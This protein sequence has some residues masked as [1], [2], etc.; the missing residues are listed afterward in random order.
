MVPCCAVSLRLPWEQGV[1]PWPMCQQCWSSRCAMKSCTWEMCCVGHGT[2]D[3]LIQCSNIQP[4]RGFFP[5]SFLGSLKNVLFFFFPESVRFLLSR[6]WYFYICWFYV[7][8]QSLYVKCIFHEIIFSFS[9][10]GCV[11][12]GQNHP[13]AVKLPVTCNSSAF[14]F[15]EILGLIIKQ[16]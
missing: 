14:A 15:F 5:L 13:Q 6:P 7:W 8:T 10:A 12:I 11:C 3:L 2:G 9:L 4:C 1:H 16:F